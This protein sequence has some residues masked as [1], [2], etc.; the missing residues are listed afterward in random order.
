[1]A[2]FMIQGSYTPQAWAAQIANPSDRL[3]AVAEMLAPTGITFKHYWYSFGDHDFVIIAEGPG[4]VET[5]AAVLAAYA[6][7][8]ALKLKTTPLLTSDECIAALGKAGDV[9]YNGLAAD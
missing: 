1:M 5:T 3:A 7:G 4:N 8:A 9:Q 2:T 6:G